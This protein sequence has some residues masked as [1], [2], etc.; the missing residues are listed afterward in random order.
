LRDR[1]IPLDGVGLQGHARTDWH[2]TPAELTATMR[3]F[4]LLGL[5]VSVT[6]LDVATDR[7]PGSLAERLALQSQVYGMYGA[8]CA[9]MPGCRGVTVWGLTDPDSWLG[10]RARA[11]PFDANYSPKPAWEA[12]V[13]AWGGSASSDAG[14]G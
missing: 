9:G 12:L 7:S 6:E 10:P 13:T 1:G 3:G 11:L 4:T 8:V 14:S 2:P 5:T